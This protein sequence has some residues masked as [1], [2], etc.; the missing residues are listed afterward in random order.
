MKVAERLGYWL[1][2]GIIFTLVVI[3]VLGSVAVV[4]QLVSVVFGTGY[5]ESFLVAIIGVFIVTA[6]GFILDRVFI[7]A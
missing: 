7:A 6:A 3:M 2:L 5:I 4:V 1:T